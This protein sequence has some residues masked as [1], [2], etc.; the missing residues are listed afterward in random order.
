MPQPS[1]D[2]NANRSSGTLGGA[3]H[4]MLITQS[5][6]WTN[7]PAGVTAA[8]TPV[9]S[10]VDF[11]YDRILK[12][13]GRISVLGAGGTLK[14]QYALDGTTWVDLTT[15]TLSTAA[16][17]VVETAYEAIPAAVQSSI[18]QVRI[19]GLTGDGAIDPAI[20]GVVLVMSR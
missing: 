9:V 8:D 3:I 5:A 2:F 15:N 11:R 1:Q 18:A 16:L 12:F 17:G 20:T 13:Q 19:V 10:T 14:L 6:V 4:Q 7:L